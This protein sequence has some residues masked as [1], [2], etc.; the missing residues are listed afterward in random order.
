MQGRARYSNEIA[1]AKHDELVAE[2][3][4]D[5]KV[6]VAS[7]EMGKIGLEEEE[8]EVEVKKSKQ[9]MRN[10]RRRKRKIEEKN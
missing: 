8:K 10:D 2:T 6:T 5:R 9:T 7:K 4:F 3:S 1:R